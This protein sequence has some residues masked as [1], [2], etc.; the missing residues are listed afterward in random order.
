MAYNGQIVD[1]FGGVED[2][3]NKI[4]RCVGEPDKR[5][6][7]DALRIMRALRFSS[8]LGFDIEK[9]TSE[10]ILRNKS[11]L[12]NISRERISVELQ[13]LIK[14]VSAQKIICDYA[15]VFDEIFKGK[16]FSQKTVYSNLQ[17]MDCVVALS[18]FFLFDDC[19]EEDLKSLK[20]SN[21]VYNNCIKVIK[22][23]DS[24]LIPD[25]VFIKKFLSE[26]GE[27]AYRYLSALQKTQGRDNT[28]A[29]SIFADVVTRGE[30][31]SIDKL[32]INGE[33]LMNL[34]LRNKQIGTALKELL[35]E[36]INSNIDNK[37][38]ELIKYAKENLI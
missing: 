19:F 7:E 17:E 14:G 38:N 20:L 11:L 12:K 8:V 34:G 3:Q 32:D 30:C 27:T 5:F 4:I 18:A 28:S 9:N 10:S 33:D 15:E 6:N 16:D 24:E 35:N 26:H 37:K 31:Y 2:L 21:E 36:V 1:L 13:K 22:L 23:Y 25:R 29:D